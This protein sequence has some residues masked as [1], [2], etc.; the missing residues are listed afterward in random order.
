[1]EVAFSTAKGVSYHGEIEEIFQDGALSEYY[2]KVSLIFTS[3]PFPLVRRKKYG[4]FKGE[5]YLKWMEN[6]AKSLGKFLKEDGSIV[7]EIGNSWVKGSP[8][9]SILPLQSLMAFL[10]AGDYNL[11]Q[12]FIWN[13]TAKLPS[14]AEWVNI[15]RIRVKDSFTNI[16]WMSPIEYPKADNKKVLNEYSESMKQLLSSK[17]YNSGVRPSEHVI[18]EK[19]FLSNN[20]GSIPSNVFSLSNTSSDTQYAKYCKDNEFPVHP[21]RMPK[22]IA[23]FFIRFLTDENDIVFDP[24]SGSNTTGFVSESLGRQ[25]VSLE[26]N[27]SYIDGSKGRFNL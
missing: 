26:K 11:C 6:V 13:N 19:S 1:M 2:G 10:D 21:A 16:W 14:P 3:P 27:A 23:E 20:N 4:N 17:K 15:R 7:I 25:W 22:E 8:A 5:V 18:G 9:M 24:F 12:Q